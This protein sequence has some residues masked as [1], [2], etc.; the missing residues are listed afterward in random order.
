MRRSTKFIPIIIE[1]FSNEMITQRAGYS[2]EVDWWALG[3]VL[4]EMLC[5]EQLY[6]ISYQNVTIDHV[7]SKLMKRINLTNI[8]EKV[9]DDL[10]ADLIYRLNEKDPRFRIGLYLNEDDGNLG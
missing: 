7:K 8:E 6:D 9:R 3:I 4:Y 10:A 5:G 1:V 2:F